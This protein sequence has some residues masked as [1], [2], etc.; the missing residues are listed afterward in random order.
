[1][2]YALYIF[3]VLVILAWIFYPRI[4]IKDKTIFTP[5]VIG[6]IGLLVLLILDLTLKDLYIDPI[7]FSF[8]GLEVHWYALWIMLGVVVAVI[9]GVREGKN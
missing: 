2:I 3:A 1:M 8:F 4:K 7:A 6:G 5:L 9:M